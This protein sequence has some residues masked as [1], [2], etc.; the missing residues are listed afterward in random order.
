MNCHAEIE[1]GQTHSDI[2]PPGCNPEN[3]TNDDWKQ[4][5]RDCLEEFL[6]NYPNYGGTARFHITIDRK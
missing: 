4:L 5:M 1:Y 3:M 2:C 6:L